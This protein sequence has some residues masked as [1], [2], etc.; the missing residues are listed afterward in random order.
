MVRVRTPGGVATAR[1]AL[2]SRLGDFG[3]AEVLT[4]RHPDLLDSSPAPGVQLDGAYWQ[5]T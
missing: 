4:S 2:T 3:F 1:S 5:P